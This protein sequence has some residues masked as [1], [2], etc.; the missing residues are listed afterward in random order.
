MEEAPRTKKSKTEENEANHARSRQNTG[1]KLG[2][3]TVHP[4]TN[5]AGRPEIWHG[6]AV[7]VW[8]DRATWHGRAKWCGAVRAFEI[9]R[10]F[11]RVFASLFGTAPRSFGEHF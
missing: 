10:L 3:R 7:L 5:T 11:K 4:R 6:Q 1:G 8:H 2:A 9:F